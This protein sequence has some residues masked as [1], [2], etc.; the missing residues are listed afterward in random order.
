MHVIL[1][2]DN[3]KIFIVVDS[4]EAVIKMQADLER[5]EKWCKYTG[6]NCF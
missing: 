4:L 5:F 1:L 2:A 6:Q 3:M